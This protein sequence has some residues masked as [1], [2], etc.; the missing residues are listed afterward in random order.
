MTIKKM[1]SLWNEAAIFY[2]FFMREMAVT[3][4]L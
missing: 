4:K 3:G 1:A 2:I